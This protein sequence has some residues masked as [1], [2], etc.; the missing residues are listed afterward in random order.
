MLDN[1][2]RRDRNRYLLHKWVLGLALPLSLITIVTGAF[3]FGLGLEEILSWK[4]L[5]VVGLT[6]VSALL[7]AVVL[8][9]RAWKRLRD[10]GELRDE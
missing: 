5:R 8:G 7:A 6:I 4:F 1:E 9:Q 2:A 3:E 10:S